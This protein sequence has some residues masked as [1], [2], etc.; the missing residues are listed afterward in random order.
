MRQQA[1][2][3]PA[4]ASPWRVLASMR[5]PSLPEKSQFSTE[6]TAHVT[7]EQDIGS[8]TALGSLYVDTGNGAA[9]IEGSV[10]TTGEQSYNGGTLSLQNVDLEAGGEVLM[11]SFVTIGP[12]T[13]PHQWQRHRISL[14]LQRPGRARHHRGTRHGQFRRSCRLRFSDHRQHPAQRSRHDHVAREPYRNR[15]RRHRDREHH[16]HWTDRLMSTSTLY[17]MDTLYRTNGTGFTEHGATILGIPAARPGGR[18][19]CRH[20]GWRLRRHRWHH[21]H[22]RRRRRGQ[23]RRRSDDRHHGCRERSVRRG[24]HL[25]LGLARSTETRRW[26]STRDRARSR[27]ARSATPR[28]SAR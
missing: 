25:R 6:A 23:H 2:T 7:I 18:R 14:C 10:T 5:A 4:P 3:R 19:R 8:G 24:G 22:R 28:R 15:R 26:P 27:L 11:N 21:H 13:T 9:V 16:Y 1:A 12:G 17:L 20:Y